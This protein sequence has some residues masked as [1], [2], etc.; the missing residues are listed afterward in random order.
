MQIIRRF[1]SWYADIFRKQK[2][3]GKVSIGCISL[4]VV[5]CVCGV[6]IALLNPATPTPRLQPTITAVIEVQ[7]TTMIPTQQ[8]ESTPLA[9]PSPAGK[10]FE[11]YGG[12]IEAY[13][14]IFSLSD[15]AKLQEKFD[16]ASENNKREKP[17]TAGFK[18]TLGY[19]TASDDRMKELGCYK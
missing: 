14:E 2:M 10:Y 19:M 4:M 6:P 8:A 15:C 17:G 1:F 9:T 16:T 11:E 7:K 12:R 13:E 18:W 3:I 5:C